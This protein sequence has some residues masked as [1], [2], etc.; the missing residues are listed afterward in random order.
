MSTLSGRAPPSREKRLD[1]LS[2]Y[3][4]EAR[5]LLQEFD[6]GEPDQRIRT[7]SQSTPDDL[8]VALQVLAGVRGAAI[9]I[10]GPRGCASSQLGRLQATG[11][12]GGGCWVV[13]NLSQRETILGADGKL[14]AAITAL[15]RRHRPEAIFVVAT[16]AVAIN[17]DDILSVV[18][19]LSDQLATPIV[20]VFASGFASKSAV[21]GYDLALTSLVKRFL[22]E[23]PDHGAQHVNLL[24]L[25]ESV[26]DRREIERL[27]AA[28]A[29]EA[30]TFPSGAGIDAFRHAATARLSV[31]LNAD[32]A[33]SLGA[34][35]QSVAGV[36]FLSPPSPIGLAAIVHWLAAVGAA[37][38]KEKDARELHAREVAD[39]SRLLETRPLRGARVYLS[40]DP[41][42]AFGIVDLVQ[43]LGG[44]IAGMSV[45]HLDR[46][47]LD[48]L[49]AL[50][51]RAPAAML[52]VGHA[53]G[54]EELNLVQRLGVDLY[55]G[56]SGHL[57]Q[58]A[59]LGIACLFLPRVPIVGYKGV[60][61]FARDAARAIRNRGFFETLS[62]RRPPYSAQ[63]FQRS[64]HWHIK[65]EVR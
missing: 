2:A 59:H 49:R 15:H 20:P 61:S 7:F 58:V 21:Q 37:I 57:A 4:G 65:Q 3:L 28:L 62:A 25:S 42:T 39:L 31:A 35:L 43:D 16:P 60:A 45:E 11:Q 40:L 34:A 17:N 23:K 48:S 33:I 63:W 51:D 26:E 22:T 6:R 1:T 5:A 55:V 53:Q 27:L 41:A 44:E 36:P 8:F 29:V 9:V 50:I 56:A 24:S 12:N 13:T 38:G 30:H 10:H 46:L 19:Q 54:F 14:H 32:Q 64:A 47:H 18:G 52:H